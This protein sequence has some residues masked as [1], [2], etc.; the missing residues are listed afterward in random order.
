MNE[1]ISSA[2]YNTKLPKSSSNTTK[3]KT[4]HTANYIH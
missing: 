3:N 4:E 2:N 1:I